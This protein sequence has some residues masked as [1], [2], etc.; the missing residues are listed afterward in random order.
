MGILNKIIK[1]EKKEEEGLA[2]KA[3]GKSGNHKNAKKKSVEK[4][5]IKTE[6]EKMKN[7]KKSD[8]KAKKISTEKLPVHYFEMIRGPHISEKAFNLTSENKYV[9]KV[10]DSSNKSEIKKAIEGFYG[11][12]ATKVNIITVPSKPKRFRGV[13]GVK[14]GYRKAVVTLAKGNSIDIMKEM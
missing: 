5:G 14:S 12:V 10:S 2:N 7:G 13:P 8:T 3:D 11:V 6:L 9:F 1:K 4:T